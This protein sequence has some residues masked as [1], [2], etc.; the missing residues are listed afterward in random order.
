M[1]Q[2]NENALPENAESPA[3]GGEGSAPAFKVELDIDDAPFLEEE[4]EEAPPEPAPA[5]APAA[6]PAKASEAAPAAKGPSFLQ[7]FLT[8]LRSDK[9]LKILLAGGLL[10]LIVVPV[11]LIFLLGG[12][13]A[14]PPPPPPPPE[15]QAPEK[16]V[17]A[18][19]EP[20]EHLFPLE[21]FFVERRGSEGEIRFLRCSFTIVTR[22]SGIQ[23]ELAVKKIVV[24]DSVYYYLHNKPLTFL[25]DK[26]AAL[27]LK[28][29]V[30]SV[31][32]EHLTLGKIDD[33]LIEDYFI[34][35]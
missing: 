5:P 15:V 27:T 21:P 32:N 19:A 22:D 10:I 9:K 8:R 18:P 1:S 14:P 16:K 4:E 20:A 2:E 23:R 12:D 34:T 25:Q 26:D 24:R 17:E 3:E 6:A 7:R 29:D 30:I 31:I 11:A 35:N 13:D 28:T 33:L